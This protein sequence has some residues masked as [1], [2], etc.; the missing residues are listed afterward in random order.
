[1]CRFSKGMCVVTI[2]AAIAICAP[3]VT[4]TI[5]GGLSVKV[6]QETA[7]PGGMVQM[8]VRTTEGKPISTGKASLNFR[9]LASVDGVSLVSPTDDVAGIA[10]VR[11]TDVA[12]SLVSP[13]N[14]FVTSEY[15]L[16]TIT[17][18][19]PVDAPMGAT[20]PM[21][22]HRGTLEVLDAL[23]VPYV[24]EGRAG[25]LTT[26]P[27][28]AIHDVVPGSATLPA[29]S[30]VTIHGSRFQRHTRVRF[31]EAELAQ[32]RYISPTRMEAVLAQQTQM[33][34]M[35]IEARNP[36]GFR[37]TFFSYQ[38]AT[39]SGAS[40]VPDMN[41]VV[42][43]F[44]NQTMQK[45]TLHLSGATTGVALQNLDATE[46]SI[47]LELFTA[48]GESVASAVFN[49]PSNQYVVRGLAEIFGVPS[50]ETAIVRLVSVSPVHVLGV[51]VDGDLRATA[52]L[53]L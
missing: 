1:M 4:A 7:P 11:G 40:V 13:N 49:V 44:G 23:G 14:S 9:W 31:K 6:S 18:R 41:E 29:G 43:L 22:F 34:G 15:P 36:D 27:A 35:E 5:A 8:K 21:T 38:R 10:M 25:Q 3:R 19:V 46:T 51:S 2:V 50:P 37:T 20:F 26:A 30:V 24:T 32:V 48:S 42:P 17:G 47:V 39:R 52:R 33:H 16:W 53:P 45:A 28:I 12:V